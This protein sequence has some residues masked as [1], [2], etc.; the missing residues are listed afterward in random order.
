MAGT[1]IPADGT[2]WDETIP[3]KDQPHGADYNELHEIKKAVRIRL[4]K[5]HVAMATASAGGEHKPGS[6]KAYYGDFSASDAGDAV[7]TRRPDAS[8]PWTSG[9]TALDS[10]DYGRLA[11][12]TD[13]TYGGLW[14]YKVGGW[15]KAAVDLIAAQTIAGIKTFS[16]KAVF[17]AG[18]SLKTDDSQL[19]EH[20]KD[21]VGN[22]DAATKKFVL[23]TVSAVV[24][25]ASAAGNESS[26][27]SVLGE[28]ELK[29]GQIVL[30]G[31][32]QTVTFATVCGS[33]FTAACFQVVACPGGPDAGTGGS[34]S[35]IYDVTATT[36][37]VSCEVYSNDT[38][39]RFI[40]I[41][42]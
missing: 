15:V 27:E 34:G 35:R 4:N 20:V 14:V 21:P 6:A 19:I 22:Q 32:P 3:D 9:G 39:L 8:S 24:P 31:S 17:N 41:G 40:A 1:T 25:A 11:Y 23:D 33:A 36:F 29:W 37:K 16:A 5:E 7:P 12:D 38:P 10:D 2:A 26:G 18:I 13:A 28:L 30:T 42:R